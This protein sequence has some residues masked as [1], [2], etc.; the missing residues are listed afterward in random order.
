MSANSDRR[1]P[2]V[3]RE[4]ALSDR[5]LNTTLIGL[6]LFIFT[7]LLIFLYNRASTGTIDPV[8]FQVTLGDAVGAAFSFA[9]SALYNYILIFWGPAEHIKGLLHRR[10]AELFFTLGLFMMLLG[11]ALILFTLGLLP[12]ASAALLLFLGYVSMYIYASRKTIPEAQK[13][14]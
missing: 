10:R 12:V 9:V 13:V 3:G 2:N 14:A 4:L 5:N 8:L 6:S 11:L 7:F 1:G